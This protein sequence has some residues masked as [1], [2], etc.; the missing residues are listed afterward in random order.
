MV[1]RKFLIMREG[2]DGGVVGRV[3]TTKI[4]AFSWVLILKLRLQLGGGP[5]KGYKTYCK[6]GSKEL[7]DLVMRHT[8]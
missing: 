4:P 2:I 7:G 5:E 3:L 1:D 6:W 8:S